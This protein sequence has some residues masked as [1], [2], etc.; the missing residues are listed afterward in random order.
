MSKMLESEQ[1]EADK[2]L[3]SLI[4]E[5]N[6]LQKVHKQ[7]VRAESKAE[8]KH[9]KA[10]KTEHK[11]KMALVHVQSAYEKAVANLKSRAEGLTAKKEHVG[12]QYTLLNRKTKEVEEIRSKKAVE[13][14]S[15]QYLRLVTYSPFDQR[16]RSSKLEALKPK[17]TGSTVAK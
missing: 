14:V 8:S 1:K 5:L 7:A 17:T 12:K 2:S 11:T 4:K 10:V 13:D 9:G 15:C 16:E 3:K 6:H